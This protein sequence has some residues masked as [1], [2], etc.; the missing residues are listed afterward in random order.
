VA[1]LASGDI[2]TLIPEGQA[3]VVCNVT[4]SS[5]PAGQPKPVAL[6]AGS[7]W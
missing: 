7:Q 5:L 6:N 3:T 4:G 1:T 2:V